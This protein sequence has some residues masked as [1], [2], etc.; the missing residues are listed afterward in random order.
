[1]RRISGRR[2]CRSCEHVA[3]V[4]PLV[5]AVECEKCGAEMFQRDDDKP[6]TVRHRLEV[7]AEQTAP[8]VGYYAERGILEGINAT[9]TVEEVTERALGVL[10][11]YQG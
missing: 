7:Y 10:R 4:D 8:L 5:A 2:T 9:G 6:D 3:D 11:R 1:M